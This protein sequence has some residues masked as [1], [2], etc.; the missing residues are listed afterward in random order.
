MAAM[1]THNHRADLRRCGLTMRQID[2]IEVV[3]PSAKA[4]LTPLSPMKAVR[5][6]LTEVIESS[7]ATINLLRRIQA[8]VQPAQA[9]AFARIYVTD[10]KKSNGALPILGVAVEALE[11]L[12]DVAVCSLEELPK[13]QRQTKAISPEILRLIDD[14]LL[15]G[16]VLNGGRGELILPTSTPR[17]AYSEIARICLLAM[18]RDDPNPEA[19]IKAHVRW[20]D[21]RKRHQ[22]REMESRG[23][24]S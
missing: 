15:R 20:R 11:R 22:F 1:L 10:A 13:R 12:R 8:G 19:M 17:G 9:E 16:I 6:E 4:W 7:E 18:G 23:G 24:N 2:E 21:A 14:A 3:L 5:K